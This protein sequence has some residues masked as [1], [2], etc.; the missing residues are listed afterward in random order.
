MHLKRSL[1]VGITYE[2]ED[3][4]VTI[5]FNR[6][7]VMN[8][9]DNKML[10]E[11]SRS[12]QTFRDDDSS[13]V[14]II[15]GAGDRAFSAGF[16]LKETIPAEFPPL[17]TRGLEIWKPIIA[18]ING[19]AIGGGFDTALACDFRIAAENAIFR[20]PGVQWGMMPGWGGTQR[21]PRI[22]GI[23]MAA[24]MLL[25]AKEINAEEALRIGL[26]NKVVPL[27]ELMNT[28]REW[29][30]RLCELGQLAV[31]AAKKVMI[32]GLSLSLD[33]GL[34]LEEEHLAQLLQTEDA[35]ECPLAFTEK[36]K[37]RF[38]GR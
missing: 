10:I 21:L 33:E 9:I 15:T 23:T 32:E 12:L 14:L 19:A 37:P 29:A 38:K 18:A 3:R 34:R 36:R 6:P 27:S 16:D 28:A 24:E 4:V 13:W 1:I 25:M 31:R 5:T 7:E 30:A 2:K 35:R 22:A 20:E 11:F 26:V 17:I 8:A